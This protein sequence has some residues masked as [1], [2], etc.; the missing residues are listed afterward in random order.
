MYYTFEIPSEVSEVLIHEVCAR[1]TQGSDLDGMPLFSYDVDRDHGILLHQ[2]PI[3]D[4]VQHELCCLFLDDIDEDSHIHD[5]LSELH[6]LYS[7]FLCAYGL[8]TYSLVG[9]YLTTI[10]TIFI[11]HMEDD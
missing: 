4:A 10:P 3:V 7:V 8:S 5:I 11:L 2:V 1:I 9:I 6:H